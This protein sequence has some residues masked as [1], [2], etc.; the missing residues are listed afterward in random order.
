[1]PA[2]RK[3][4]LLLEQATELVVIEATLAGF[5]KRT[6]ME[7]PAVHGPAL[8]SATRGCEVE[9]TADPPAC[10]TQGFSTYGTATGGYTM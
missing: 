6:R 5:E 9:C 10:V 2:T 8:N 4:A 3:L 1:M 7:L